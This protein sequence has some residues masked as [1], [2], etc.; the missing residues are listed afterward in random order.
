MAPAARRR[1]AALEVGPATGQ[2]LGGAAASRSIAD[3]VAREIALCRQRAAL[4]QKRA[5]EHAPSRELVPRFARRWRKAWR[6]HARKVRA[7]LGDRLH[8]GGPAK[9]GPTRPAPAKPELTGDIA[10]RRVRRIIETHA[11]CLAA[12]A[13]I[14]TGRKSYRIEPVPE[15]VL[16]LLHNSLP[17]NSGGYAVRAHGLLRALRDCG[18]DAQAVLRP[19]FPQD[20]IPTAPAPAAVTLIDHA[21]YR[22]FTRPAVDMQRHEADLYVAGYARQLREL[23]ETFRPSVI[24]AASFFR[25]GLAAAHV[26]AELGIPV[27]Y[28]LRVLSI[29]GLLSAPGDPPLER[30]TVLTRVRWEFELELE[31]AHK[32]DRVLTITGALRDLLVEQGVVP[33]KISVLP[34]GVDCREFV[35]RPRSPEIEQ[36][37]DLA[38]RF[39]IGFIGSIVDY[40]GL[41]DLALALSLLPHQLRRRWRLLIVGDGEFLPILEQTVERLGLRSNVV[42]VGR[43]PHARVRDFYSVCDLVAY[44]RKP[45]PICEM[46][47]PLKPLE[48]MALGIPVVASDVGALREMIVD[49]VTGWCFPKGDCR[50]LAGLIGD[51]ISRRIDVRPIRR[52]SRRWVAANRD[53][54][55][56]A[57]PVAELY[58]QLYLD[59]GRRT[60]ARVRQRKLRTTALSDRPAAL[61]AYCSELDGGFLTRARI[62]DLTTLPPC[63]EVAAAVA[64]FHRLQPER[65]LYGDET[66]EIA[67][68]GHVLGQLPG[69]QR[70]LDVGP[71]MG[72]LLRAVS[73]RGL[74]EEL[75]AI[76]IRRYPGLLDLD[77][78]IRFQTMSATAL[79]FPDGHFTAVTCLEVL[80]HLPQ[81]QLPVAL[82]E[83]RR[84][85]RGTLLVS[86]PF[87]EPAPLAKFHRI[88]FD[89]S[90]L[91]E[92]FPH[93]EHTILLKRD[94]LKWP[95]AL[96]VER[97]DA[98]A[99]DAAAGAA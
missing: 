51:I 35:A 75:S 81:D 68:L 87:R 12:A 18:Y 11:R 9:P 20:R 79:D 47:S 46:I 83:L 4:V 80:E 7:W 17:Y 32:A 89:E 93:A 92:L 53:W 30:Q 34:N 5:L 64:E 76:D 91:L 49:G 86:V 48:P 88:R 15:R 71:S 33:E 40:E 42:F 37:H 70:L 67:R 8:G 1:R 69:G 55:Q 96:C 38:G 43:V 85:C 73:R 19:G 44:P 78:T 84:V 61:A 90:R 29:L 6:R 52:E 3:A 82:A 74:Y 98:P 59:A 72:V 36:A 16:Y 60:A 39:V 10:A 65:R 26:G 58:R 63:A 56:L 28:E 95:W 62:V 24:H 23:C 22:F 13:A 66:I 31:A 45:W 50:A 27:I 97:R 21:P 77:G 14:D 94:L 54:R 2:P 57:R 99:S 25:N 41:D